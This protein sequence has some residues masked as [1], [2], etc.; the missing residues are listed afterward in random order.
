MRSARAVQANP[1]G[2]VCH[3]GIYRREVTGRPQVAAA[4]SGRPTRGQRRKVCSVALNAAVQ[5]LKDE[6]APIRACFASRKRPFYMARGWK[7]FDANLVRAARG[8]RFDAIGPT[9]THQALHRRGIIDRADCV[10][11]DAPAA[12]NSQSYL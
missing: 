6:G 11:T 4:A 2:V 9:S 8:G 10:L 3:V 1:K 12:Y 7:P 5:T